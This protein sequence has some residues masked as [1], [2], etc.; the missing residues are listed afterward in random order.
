M[1]ASSPDHVLAVGVF[2]G[3]SAEGEV[4]FLL[5]AIRF[6][7]SSPEEVE[8]LIEVFGL[9]RSSIHQRIS[10]QEEL[11]EGHS[12][13]SQRRPGREWEMKSE[14]FP[15]AE[16]EWRWLEFLIQ[17]TGTITQKLEAG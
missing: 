17:K 8:H 9:A 16:R 6:K 10:S 2:V 11:I 13:R 3:W 15:K 4:E 14:T 12:D 5:E 7:E 1:V